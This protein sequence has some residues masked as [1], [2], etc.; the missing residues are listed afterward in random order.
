MAKENYSP[1]SGNIIGKEFSYKNMMVIKFPMCLWVSN[2]K[3]NAVFRISQ[4][5]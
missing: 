2:L 1:S 5:K 3:T 4:E